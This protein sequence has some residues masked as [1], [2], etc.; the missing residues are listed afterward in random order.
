MRASYDF[1]KAVGNPSAKRLKQQI[2]IRLETDVV[3]YFKGLSGKTGV[4]Y[5]ILINL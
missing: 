3:R 1:A 2:T 5:Q 4:P